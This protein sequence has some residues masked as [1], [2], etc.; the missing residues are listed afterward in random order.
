MNEYK[1][2]NK[3]WL[4]Y[5]INIHNNDTNKYYRNMTDDEFIDEA[6][7]YGNIYTLSGFQEAFNTEKV[8]TRDEVI[9]IL[10][11]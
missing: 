3:E 6:E 2:N 8:Y 9:R 1:D 5:I 4:V 7:S 10:Y 11:V